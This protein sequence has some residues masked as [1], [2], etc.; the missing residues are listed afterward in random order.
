[1]M[2]LGMY[3]SYQFVSLPKKSHSDRGLLPFLPVYQYSCIVHVNPYSQL[4]NR[5]AILFVLIL[6][7]GKKHFPCMSGDQVLLM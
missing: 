4:S 3:P 1:M 2:R 5:K 7:V 6:S